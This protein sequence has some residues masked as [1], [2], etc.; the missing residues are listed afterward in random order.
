M[1][2]VVELDSLRLD[3]VEA[4]V[5]R[6]TRNKIYGSALDMFNVLIEILTGVCALAR[7]RWT[8]DVDNISLIGGI[9]YLLEVAVVG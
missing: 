8:G 1:Q 9:G 2:R 5:R 3:L 7:A 6:E 4:L